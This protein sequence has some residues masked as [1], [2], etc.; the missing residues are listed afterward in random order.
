MSDTHRHPVDLEACFAGDAA[1]WT[2]F[3]DGTIGLVITAVRRT[4]GGPGPPGMDVDD[5]VQQVYV[6]LLQHDRRLLRSYDPARSALSTWITL[7]TRSTTIDALRRKR[8][9]TVHVDAALRIPTED[10]PPE[11]RE[12]ALN[13]IPIDILT[14][15]QILVLRLL[16]DDGLDVTDAAAMLGVEPQTIRSTRHKAIERLRTH[17]GPEAS[18]TT[19]AGEG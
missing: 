13:A 15:R 10:Q 19:T 18:K 2:A 14:D 3:V 17:F 4:M 16:Y 6:R 12:S 1:A 11:A 5:L 9:P 7:V 8:L